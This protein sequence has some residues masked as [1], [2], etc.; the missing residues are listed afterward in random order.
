LEGK[1]AM[2]RLHALTIAALCAGLMLLLPAHLRAG[3]LESEMDDHDN[4]APFFGEA[5]DVS[6]QRP[7]AAVQVKVLAKGG[8]PIFINTNDEGIFRLGGLGKSV[9]PDTV[10]I[11][12]AKQGYRTL[13]VLRRR[14]SRA[15]DAP[16]QIECLL[17]PEK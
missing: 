13:D 8:W 14:M 12:C 4:G 6:S 7:L 11:A 2:R 9:N 10:E 15:E 1:L 3:E 16:V 17:E 5:K